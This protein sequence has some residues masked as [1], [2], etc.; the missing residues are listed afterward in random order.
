MT[1]D[2][3]KKKAA[4]FDFDGT[5]LDSMSAFANI[6]ARVINKN[7]GVESGE[8]KRLYLNSSGIPFFQQ[9]ESLFPGHKRNR[10][11]AIEFEH[12]KLFDFFEEPVYSDVPSTIDSL[13]KCGLK[14]AVSSNNYQHLVRRYVTNAGVDF[15]LVLGFMDDFAKGAEH[16]RYITRTLRIAPNEMVFVGDSL[17]DAERAYDFG[18]DFIGKAGTFTKEQFK[19]AYPRATVIENISEMKSLL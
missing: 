16:F 6:A 13:R 12:T 8:A 17:K 5:L 15:D 14:T 2:L 3:S 19:K 4:V 7:H 10:D 18:V 9:L 1:L 11:A